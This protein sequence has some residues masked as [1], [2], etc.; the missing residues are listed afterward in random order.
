MSRDG[1]YLGSFLCLSLQQR[2]HPVE[3]REKECF[4]KNKNAPRKRVVQ[5]NNLQV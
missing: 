2:T 3:P 4:S 5:N 1:V